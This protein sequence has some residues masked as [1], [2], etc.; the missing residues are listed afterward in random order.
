MPFN[1]GYVYT[2]DA[3]SVELLSVYPLPDALTCQSIASVAEATGQGNPGLHEYGL[4]IIA[5]RLP[6]SASLAAVVPS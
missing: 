1:N 2:S 3:T 6:P 4:R 5:S